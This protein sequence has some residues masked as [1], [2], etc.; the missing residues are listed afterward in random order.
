MGRLISFWEKL[1]ARFHSEEHRFIRVSVYAVL[2]KNDQVLLCRLSEQLGLDAG[3]WTLPGGGIEFGEPII[4][5][6]Y[7]EVKEET[8]LL[9][10]FE[11]WL[12]V[13]EDTFT[14]SQNS[15]QV[16]RLIALAR[17]VSGELQYEIDGSTD[18]AQWHPLDSVEN[19]PLV[20]TAREALAEQKKTESAR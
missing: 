15:T 1:T 9:I 14:N 19:L 3:R 13:S 8:G 12:T 4:E 6:L 11:S 20:K 2:I 17:V 10:E 16:I 5:A 7:R 18:M